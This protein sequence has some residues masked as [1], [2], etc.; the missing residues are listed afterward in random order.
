MKRVTL[1]RALNTRQVCWFADGEVRTRV[2]VVPELVLD[3]VE[4][5]LDRET[6]VAA[7]Q[8]ATEAG[9]WTL[10][11]TLAAQYRIRDCLHCGD[12]HPRNRVQRLLDEHPNAEREHHVGNARICALCV[13]VLFP[14]R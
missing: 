3:V 7:I 4:D 10:A 1:T 11:A 12:K 9:E 8:A 5:E 14:D 6:I 2:V 13:G